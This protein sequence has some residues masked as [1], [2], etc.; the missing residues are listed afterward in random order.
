[1]NIK[2]RPNAHGELG[3]VYVDVEG[4]QPVWPM[5]PFQDLEHLAVPTEF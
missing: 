2:S 3:L 4:H 1:M 5:Q